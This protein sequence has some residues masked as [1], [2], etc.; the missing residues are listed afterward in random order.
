[1]PKIP[2][3]PRLA[4]S[5]LR[6]IRPFGYIARSR[7]SQPASEPT[8]TA[9]LVPIG[10]LE[11]VQTLVRVSGRTIRVSDPKPY[12]DKRS[13][14]Q[15]LWVQTLTIKDELDSIDVK[16]WHRSQ[17]H[18]NQYWWLKLDLLIHVWTDDVKLNATD[19][20]DGST[21]PSTTSPLVM[22]VS[23]GKHGHQIVS[24]SPE[25]NEALFRTALGVNAG[26]I[27]QSF[28]LEQLLGAG[29]SLHQQQRLHLP[30]LVKKVGV[31][32][33]VRTRFG[34][35]CKRTLVVLDGQ[36]REANLTFWGALTSRSAEDWIANETVLV[37]TAPKVG[38]YNQML[39]VSVSFQTHVQVNPVCKTV[40]WLRHAALSFVA[41]GQTNQ[42]PAAS[43]VALDQITTFYTIREISETIPTL[44]SL[45][46]SYGYTIGVISQL[47]IEDPGFDLMSATWQAEPPAETWK[48][49]LSKLIA[50]MDN[51]GELRHPNVDPHVAQ[52]MLGFSA[53][54]F[55]GLNSTE[56]MQVK[57]STLDFGCT[58][59]EET[60]YEQ[61]RT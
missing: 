60:L 52:K 56:R 34:E 39:D 55:S 43:E 27:I 26:G 11:A 25:E 1:M 50:F 54:E 12:K 36:G 45:S 29:D 14:S 57:A 23:E 4:P 8:L 40:E 46:A 58:G 42:P 41:T 32:S 59:R 33:L 21:V 30:V 5:T 44:S 13:P 18:V 53:S 19:S 9:V 38:M 24:G 7:L 16:I 10:R 35:T 3:I 31:E 20:M 51:T 28:H 2:P 47:D 61:H 49:T 22:T 15:T 17:D 37:L 48:F 6:T